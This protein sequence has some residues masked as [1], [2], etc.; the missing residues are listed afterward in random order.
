MAEGQM[1]AAA[2]HPVVFLSGPELLRV[3][4][5]GSFTERQLATELLDYRTNVVT[6]LRLYRMEHGSR[7]LSPCLAPHRCRPCAETDARLA[8]L[9]ARG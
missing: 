7:R 2:V 8:A 1:D 6:L 3:Q 4:E 5:G 9:A